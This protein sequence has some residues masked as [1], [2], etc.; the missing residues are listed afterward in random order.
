MNSHLFKPPGVW[1]RTTCRLID[2]SQERRFLL[3]G[4]RE[5]ENCTTF[6]QLAYPSFFLFLPSPVP[7]ISL[8]PPKGK[9]E[10]SLCFTE[11]IGKHDHAFH[12]K[13]NK[14]LFLHSTYPSNVLFFQQHQLS[15]NGTLMPNIQIKISST[16]IH[17]I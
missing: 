16:F 17:K 10:S 6:S 7:F 4:T 3:W 11:S 5:G 8:S 15:L 12:L 2:P 1:F 9:A 14:H 13:C